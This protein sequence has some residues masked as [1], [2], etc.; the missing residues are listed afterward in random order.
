MKVIK[1]SGLI[2]FLLGLTIFVGTIFTGS[3]NL[4]Q[5]DLD[6][7]I[8]KKNYKS[9]VIKSNLEKAIVTSEDLNIFQF[10]KRVI[11]AYESSNLYYDKL[12]QKYNKEK[13]WK[14]KGKQYQYKIGGKPHS[15]S[16]ILA[17][18]AGKGWASENTTL[19]W[20]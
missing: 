18:K 8:K 17:K 10:S 7:F 15:L 14:E 19:M 3:F 11:K 12:I 16:F 5:L 9:V 1:Q 20:F 13:N 4:N 2:I 6:T